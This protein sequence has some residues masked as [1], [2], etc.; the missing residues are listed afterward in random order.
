MPD[1]WTARNYLPQDLYDQFT[2]ALG[3][4]WQAD[5]YISTFRNN[6][7]NMTGE[8]PG[9]QEIQGFIK[10]AGVTSAGL[11]GDLGYSDL[12][13]LASTYTQDNYGDAVQKLQQKKEAD[14]LSGVQKQIDDL[15]SKQSD[16]AVKQ[17]T[18][19]QN[20]A[21]LKGAYNNNG[22]LDS[23]AYAEGV[24]N[25][26]ADAT[27]GNISSALGSVTLPAL[28]NMQG[29]SSAPYAQQL[30]NRYSGLDHMN[31]MSDFGLQSSIA[32]MLADQAA[33]SGFD[34]GIGYTSSL[35]NGLGNAAK[36]GASIAATSYICL[37]M[38]D[39]GL[40]CESD[41]DDFHVHIIPAVLKKGRAFW[42]YA[43]FGQD[44]AR[45][46]K[47][48][49]ID[50]AKY[51]PLLFDRVMQTTNPCDAVDLYADALKEICQRYAPHLWDERVFRTSLLD[52]LP[53]IP[54]L[55]TFKPF[56][57]AF[58][59]WLRVKT[60]LVYDKPRCGVHYES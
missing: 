16:Q 59:K 2:K 55:A 40:L 57:R 42:H 4:T 36:G 32:K 18:N 53:F 31:Q 39:A 51:K 34:K 17:L 10:N 12:S 37:A 20:V 6:Y 48:G 50:W 13:N 25:R 3:G 54:K 60:L 9:L 21:A 56:R 22:M 38:I 29:L 5:Q 43:K 44:L 15:I 30:N 19:P 33:P 8:D 47:A 35:L 58:Q 26:M 1:Q 46:A 27:A 14:S 28:G 52:S 7:K 45:F 49:G 41:L 11:P 23:G 24:G